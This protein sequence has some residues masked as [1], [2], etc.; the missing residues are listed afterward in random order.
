MWLLP[1][2]YG[3]NL[4]QNNEMIHLRLPELNEKAR[5]LCINS[6]CIFRIII[7]KSERDHNYLN[8]NIYLS[9]FLTA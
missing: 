7:A 2:S 5:Q 4:R 9:N 6:F 3:E 8:S 1:I